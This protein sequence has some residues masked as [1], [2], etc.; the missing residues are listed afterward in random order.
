MISII[1]SA[2]PMPSTCKRY[3]LP[4]AIFA[5]IAQASTHGFRTWNRKRR[6][7]INDICANFAGL[8]LWPR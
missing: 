6:H 4:V 2:T 7:A 5:E 3:H 8:V 1:A